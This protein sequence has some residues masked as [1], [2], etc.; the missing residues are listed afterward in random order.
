MQEN[1]KND[2]IKLEKNGKINEKEVGTMEQEKVIEV[3]VSEDGLQAF[4]KVSPDK[5]ENVTVKQ[6]DEALLQHQI[7]YGI[8]K[9]VL[10][11]VVEHKRYFVEVQ[12]AS[13]LE[14]TDGKDGYY[15][16]LFDTDVDVKP[17]ILKDGSVDYKSMGEIPVV[18]ENQELVHYHSATPPVNGKNVYGGEIVG[19]KGRDLLGLKGRGFLLSEDKKVYRA[20][21]TGKVTLTGNK[22]VVS[23]VLVLNNDVSTSSGGVHF[24]GDIV[25]KGNV[26]TGAE[27]W[28]KGN[29]EVNGCVEAAILTAGK[30]VVLKNGM[31]GNGKGIIKA[32][33]DVSGKFFEQVTI[34][35]KGNVSANAVMN[36]DIACGDAVNIAGR[37]G[38][39][40]GGKVSALREIEATMIGNMSE[41]KTVLEVGTSEDLYEKLGHVEGKIRQ[42]ELELLKLKGVAEKNS[43]MAESQQDKLRIM[44]TKIEREAELTELSKEKQE[45]LDRMAKV[46]NAKIIVRKSIYP[47][48]RLTI[49]GILE[50]I[51][52]ENYNV[53]YQKQGVEI[54]F[55]ANI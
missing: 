54:G 20:A 36:C 1:T 17:K 5:G 28:A 32:G 38:V 13:G 19:K 27:V 55:T 51:R 50:K 40:V 3:W 14:P 23:N 9:D 31:Q 25:I 24:A 49:N 6:L 10:R 39:I 35:A 15:E 11:D 34:E 42:A 8:D 43:K 52:T 29:I 21:L 12:V 18:E 45:L 22:L 37:F 46:S 48:A 4:L 16:Y 53:T 2:I 7:V 30:N 41:T 26:L 44:R 47:G 33:K